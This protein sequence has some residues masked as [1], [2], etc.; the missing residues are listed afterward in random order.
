MLA[1]DEAVEGL[2]GGVLAHGMP[3]RLAASPT[4]AESVLPELL[5]DFE[6]RHE[7][8]LSVE[9][10]IVS[11]ATARELVR[12]GRVDLG[13]AAADPSLQDAGPLIQIPICDDE[14]V[15]VVPQ[16]H[17]WAAVQEIDLAEF[18]STPMIMR[19]PGADSRRTVDAVLRPLGLS[20]SPP[21]AEIGNTAAGKDAALHE[22]APL[23]LSR[24]TMGAADERLLVRRV[25]GLRF[26]RRF[27]LLYGTAEGLS[28]MGRALVEHL[29][30][31]VS[32]EGKIGPATQVDSRA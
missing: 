11:S 23:L 15:V 25:A 9:L 13:L 1:E 19:D 8:H 12:E 7:R 2:M 16:N 29:R 3:A 21:L 10:T 18:L 28:P 24:L 17:P 6:D 14:V 22:G 30:T 4:M 27:V 26:P 20:L 32:G 5:V 31:S